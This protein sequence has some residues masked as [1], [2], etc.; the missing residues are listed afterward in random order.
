MAIPLIRMINKVNLYVEAH[1]GYSMLKVTM[2]AL[3]KYDSVAA[4][5]GSD[6]V[7]ELGKIAA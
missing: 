3:E 2:G 4:V 5:F 1:R 6:H 7:T